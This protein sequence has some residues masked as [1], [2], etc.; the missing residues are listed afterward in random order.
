MGNS[1]VLDRDAI[2]QWIAD[3]PDVNDAK[4]L[5]ELLALS[6]DGD[7]GAT[8]ELQDRFSGL[9]TFGTAGLRGALGAG[10]NRMNRAVVIRAAAGL[11]AFLKS[12]LPDG[13]NV[14]VGYDARRGSNKFAIDTA[15]VIEAAGGHAYVF[16]KALPT[17]LTAFALRHLDADAA[18]MV[19]A[20]HNPPEDN[21]YKVYLGGRVVTGGG[22]GAQIVAPYDTKILNEILAV[23]S[24][25][26]VPRAKS[27]WEFLGDELVDA[28]VER[29]KKIVPEGAR[30]LKI[31]LTP[32][33]GVGGELGV[34]VLNEC[35]FEDITVVPQQ[36]DPD[37]LFP[38]VAFPN[39]EEPGAL[40]L[41]M[42]LAREVDADIIL[43]Y[44]PDADR[45]SAALPNDSIASGWRQ[46]SGD[47]VGTLLGEQ[48]IREVLT[49]PD[50]DLETATVANSIVSSRLLGRVAESLGVNHTET[51][52][53]FK[54][55]S[56]VP[57]IVYGYEEALGYC[58][59]PDYVRDKDGISAA[60]K[61]AALAARA[62]ANGVD[63][64]ERSD[65]LA[66]KFGL[67][68]TAPLTIRVEDLSLIAQ[69]MENLR[70]AAPAE[71]AGSP[72]VES[73]DLAQEGGALPPTD[74]LVYFTARNDRVIVRPSGT[75]PKLKCYLEVVEP[76][77][78]HSVDAARVRAT[79]RL[80]DIKADMS[81]AL[82]I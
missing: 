49:D 36:R 29:V 25:A 33:H 54:W 65:E 74:A 81:K 14:V 80:N 1:P 60:A 18:V 79:Q 5:E 40:D 2:L 75:E 17:P 77:T 44:D 66:I 68:A 50:V 26:S 56:R 38:T 37:P 43:A 48:K 7:E 42:E 51:L 28:Y 41:A 57:G 69:G 27:G 53:G 35:G 45:A 8:A 10:P 30:D 31:V 61:L 15:A 47:E 76:V 24:V 16:D 39:P 4:E 78:G 11:A 63:L 46:M 9:L 32:M 64:Q 71:I 52:T 82:G 73:A 13:F 34:R 3:D 6:D 67:Y 58:V 12:E 62:K 59:D 21:G 70:A 19:T 20:S 55:I 22:Q 23:P 72:V